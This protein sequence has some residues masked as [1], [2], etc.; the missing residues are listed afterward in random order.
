MFLCTTSHCSLAQKYSLQP[1]SGSTGFP[2]AL[3][4]LRPVYSLSAFCS[5]TGSSH[6]WPALTHSSV[7]HEPSKENSRNHT[8]PSATHSVYTSERKRLKN[9]TK[10]FRKQ[11]CSDIMEMSNCGTKWL[12]ALNVAQHPHFPHK[13]TG[14]CP[15]PHR[16]GTGRSLGSEGA[17]DLLRR[18]FSWAGWLMVKW[19][20]RPLRS[21]VVA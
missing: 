2:P 19:R 16:A 13:E 15:R 9:L 5:V 11:Q 14:T 18:D 10:V 20:A 7:F 1:G 21:R 8:T 4:C 12:L 6:G 17:G 3:T